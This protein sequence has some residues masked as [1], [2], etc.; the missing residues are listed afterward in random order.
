MAYFY[1]DR[2]HDEIAEPLAKRSI[3]I[4]R[5]SL[6]PK[7]PSTAWA[8]SMLSLVD[9][10]EGKFAEAEGL[11]REA[12]PILESSSGLQSYDLQTGRRVR[13]V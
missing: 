4:C 13:L 7:D 6:G 8:L 11:A 12:I 5:S 1:Y 3:A 2:N 9:D 10:G